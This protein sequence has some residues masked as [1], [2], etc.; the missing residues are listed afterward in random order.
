MEAFK[1]C[2]IK[3]RAAI[4]FVCGWGHLGK[5]HAANA[6][7]MKLIIIQKLTGTNLLENLFID[8]IPRD[9][10]FFK[11]ICSL[12]FASICGGEVTYPTSHPQCVSEVKANVVV[13]HMSA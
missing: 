7:F 3:W 2:S 4:Y 11:T 10:F 1:C 5:T 6:N 9:S 13:C 12:G 8:R